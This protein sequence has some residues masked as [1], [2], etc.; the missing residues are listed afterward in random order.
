MIYNIIIFDFDNTLCRINIHLLQVTTYDIDDKNKTIKIN[1]KIIPLKELFN[2]YDELLTT[3][4]TI[5]NQGTK[6]CIAS[7]GNIDNIN[8]IINI[9]FP[10]IFDYVLTSDNINKEANQYVF[11]IARHIID[12][13]CPSFYGKNIMIRTIMKKFNI[14]DP[15]TVLF[16]DDD[17][18]NT[19]CAKKINIRSHN[20]I[21]TGINSDIIKKLI[22]ND[23]SQTGGKYKYIKYYHKNNI[24]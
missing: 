9:M 23:T 11:M 20:N 10:N 15:R 5:K 21:N 14:N 6:L 13:S 1:N 2:N 4:Q 8:K 12:L 17:S 16:F 7:F 3:L 19:I 22:Y 24:L 18:S